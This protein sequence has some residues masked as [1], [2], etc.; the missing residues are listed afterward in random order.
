[1]EV[2][3]DQNE[4]TFRNNEAENDASYLV[5]AA[6]L[7]Q[8]NVRWGEL[9]S[10]KA[11]SKEIKAF[12][13]TMAKAHSADLAELQTLAT[14]KEISLPAAPMDNTMDAHDEL[15]ELTGP[16]FDMMYCE[17]VVSSHTEAIEK[18]E[19]IEQNVQDPEIRSW[20]TKILPHLR[21]HVSS[22]ETLQ[23]SLKE[24]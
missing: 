6:T 15:D 3:E 13:I 21:S 10:S 24:K 20:I 8:K 19:S 7:L 17:K 9:A 2:A 23:N 5:D 1:V 18:M 12:G 4:G 22:A 16:D 11:T 14:S